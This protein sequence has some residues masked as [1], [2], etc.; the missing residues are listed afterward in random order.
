MDRLRSLGNALVPQIAEWLGQRIMAYEAG[1]S[2][3][4]ALV[5]GQPKWATPKATDAE[6]GG[7]GDLLQQVRGNPSP[8]GHFK[9]P[10]A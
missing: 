7:R 5:G 3:D 8:S 1:L 4:P 2:S 9:M 10:D 6:R